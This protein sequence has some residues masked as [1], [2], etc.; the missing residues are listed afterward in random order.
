MEGGKKEDPRTRQKATPVMTESDSWVTSS[1]ISHWWDFSAVHRVTVILRCR[2]SPAFPR[3]PGPVG[4]GEGKV[5]RAKMGET[6]WSQKNAKKNNIH[7]NVANSVVFV[8]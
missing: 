3:E 6:F 4:R 2:T 1:N 7:D 8:L 5:Y